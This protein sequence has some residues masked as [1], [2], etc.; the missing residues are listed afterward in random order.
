MKFLKGLALFF[1][2]I[3]ALYLVGPQVENPVFSDKINYV[4]ADLDSLQ[5]WIHKRE[6][7]LGNV[8]YDNESKIY[9]EDSIP[10]KTDYSVIYFHGFT[11]SGKEGDPVHKMVA[12][13]FDANLYVP[14]LHGH[15]L[16]EEEPMLNF[17][18][19]DFWESGKEALEV[20]KRL[21]DKIIVLGTSHG[22][23]L[24]LALANDVQIE[25]LALYAP[26]IKVFDPKAS[27]LSKPWG[28]QIARLV[29]GGN[30]HFMQTDNE[31]KKKYWTTK[32]RLESTTQMQKFLDIKMRKSTFQNVK[33]PV[34]LGY[35]YE[36]DSL[37][38]KV[39]SVAAMRKMFD[40]LGTPDSLKYQKAFDGIKEHVLTSY[41]SNDLYKQVADE[42]I[43]F[44]KQILKN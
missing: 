9:F 16:D 19:E 21:G 11:A 14:R 33:V 7:A 13:A 38:D 18:N 17:N 28:L 24:G 25:A 41:L 29:K 35:Y 32:A 6:Q 15:G 42:T 36:N 27:L 43:I 31:E 12:H 22:G 26:N 39:V 34:F 37:Q 44:L 40:Q 1:L 20:A 23:S 30:Y 5:K 2:I 8:R 3:G 4:P 10:Q